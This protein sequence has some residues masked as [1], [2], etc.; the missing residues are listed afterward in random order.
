M[1]SRVRTQIGLEFAH[2]HVQGTIKTKVVIRDKMT[3]PPS[4]CCCVKYWASIRTHLAVL[5][6]R[7][8]GGL[9]LREEHAMSTT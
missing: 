3:C 4:A 9:L 5:L 6:L 2:V 1:N 7:I 8:Q